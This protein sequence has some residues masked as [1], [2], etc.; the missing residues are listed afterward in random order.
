M[1]PR[2]IYHPHARLKAFGHDPAFHL[3]RPAPVSTRPLH[4]LDA[5]IKT[6]A[7]ICHRR[8]LLTAQNRNIAARSAHWNH[9]NQWDADGAY[10]QLATADPVN[11]MGLRENR[12]FSTSFTGPP[13][14]NTDR[15]VTKSAANG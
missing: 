4:N 2:D 6:V 9:S 1:P 10:S 3:V 5:S 15:E 11:K 8:L 7:P 14:A 13:R 12:K